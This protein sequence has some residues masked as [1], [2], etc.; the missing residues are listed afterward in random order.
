MIDSCVRCILASAVSNLTS[1]QNFWVGIVTSTETGSSIDGC[2]FIFTL[3]HAKWIKIG[4]EIGTITDAISAHLGMIGVFAATHSSAWIHLGVVEVFALTFSSD[5][6]DSSM[7]YIFTTAIPDI[8]SGQNDWVGIITLTETV[9]SID[10]SPFIL[11]LADAIRI[12]ICIGIFAK[13]NAFRIKISMVWVFASADSVCIYLSIIS[14]YA[15]AR[16][17]V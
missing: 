8:T 16:S 4:I 9:T 2:P 17:F 14:I 10:R 3:A 11:T 5:M 13:A 12:Q 1:G 6:I 7:I 15:V